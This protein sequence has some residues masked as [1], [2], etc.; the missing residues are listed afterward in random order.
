MKLT[1]LTGTFLMAVLSGESNTAAYLPSGCC[2]NVNRTVRVVLA[3]TA[4]LPSQGPESSCCAKAW[5]PATSVASSSAILSSLP[6]LLPRQGQGRGVGTLRSRRHPLTHQCLARQCA[7][8]LHGR[9]AGL[10]GELA[11]AQ[12]RLAKRQPLHAPAGNIQEPA[13][14]ATVVDLQTHDQ[15]DTA[16]RRRERARPFARDRSERLGAQLQGKD[17]RSHVAFLQDHRY[18]GRRI[19]S[20]PI[21]SVE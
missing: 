3:S 21:Q 6:M 18:P 8:E 17:R 15:S 9:P 5:L 19:A 13:I 1:A 14:L 7:L 11:R 2:E 10:G 16:L 20:L 4:S 12:V